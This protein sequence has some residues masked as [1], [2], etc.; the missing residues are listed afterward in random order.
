MTPP[1]AIKYF[2]DQKL[3]EVFELANV[4]RLIPSPTVN[5]G[6]SAAYYPYV[7]PATKIPYPPSDLL[8]Q[9]LALEKPGQTLVFQDLPEKHWYVAVLEERPVLSFDDRNKD[10]GFIDLYADASNPQKDQF[11]RSTSR[12]N[13][14][15]SLRRS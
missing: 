5:P 2:N 7:I 8:D 14:R 6:V 1:E 9:F 3:G 13:G 4:A 11:W 10:K 15:R 12:A